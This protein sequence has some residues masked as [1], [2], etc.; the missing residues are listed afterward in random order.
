MRWA[1]RER[2]DSA[3]VPRIDGVVTGPN[4]NEQLYW[5]CFKFW[6]ILPWYPAPSGAG[7]KKGKICQ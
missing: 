5:L 1:V 7:V 6:E 2:L 3:T 4:A